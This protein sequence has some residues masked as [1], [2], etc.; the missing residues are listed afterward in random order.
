VI[1]HQ[2]KNNGEVYA[3]TSFHRCNCGLIIGFGAKQFLFPPKKAEADI[4]AVPTMN[5]LQ[6]HS[7]IDTKT[8][9]VQKMND[10]SVVFDSE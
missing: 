9:P 4:G 10:M 3:Q 2:Q 6:M 7:D 8:L 1:A 5:V